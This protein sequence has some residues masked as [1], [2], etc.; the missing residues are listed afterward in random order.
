MIPQA[1]HIY[2]PYTPKEVGIYKDMHILS[3]NILPNAKSWFRKNLHF[4]HGGTLLISDTFQW[5][6][7]PLY[8]KKERKK[9]HF[10]H[11]VLK[12]QLSFG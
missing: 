9:K 1:K 12:V 5:A 8:K 7:F 11:E 3:Q 10:F 4:V 2:M 6:L